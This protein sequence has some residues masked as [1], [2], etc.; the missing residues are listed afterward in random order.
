MPAVDFTAA[1]AA[2]LEIGRESRYGPAR[3]Q[4]MPAP[5]MAEE[6]DYG[7][8]LG[9]RFIIKRPRL[10]RLLDATRSRIVMLI[11]PAGYGKT[12]LA[13]EWLADRRHGW[14]RGTTAS[15]DVAALAVGLA[16]V[17]AGVVA[18][19][20]RRM[21]E[22]LVATGTPEQDVDTLAD[23]LAEDLAEWPEDAWIAFDDYHFAADSQFSERFVELLVSRCPVRLLLASR[24]RPSWA[25]AR[26]LLYGE[27]YEMGRSLLAMSQDEASEVLSH[28]NEAEASGLLAL[29]DGWPAVIGLAAH[30]ETL[31]LPDETL[32]GALHDY[33]AEELFQAADP[34]V[35]WGL[36]RLALIPSVRSDLARAVLE[37]STERVF[38]EGLRLGFLTTPAKG[39]IDLHPLLRAFLE[40]KLRD[41]PRDE[42]ERAASALFD[43]LVGRELWD[44]AFSVVEEYYRGESFLRLL[45][46]AMPDLLREARLPTLSRWLECA[47]AHRTESPLI[48]LADAELAFRQGDKAQ[49]ETLALQ[50]AQGLGDGHRLTSAAY[51]LAGSSAHLRYRDALA[52]EHFDRAQATATSERD[53][54][55]ALWGRFL[56]TVGLEQAEEASAIFVR[57]EERTPRGPEGLA[58]LANGLI[59]LSQLQGDIREA[60]EWATSL[61]PSPEMVDPLVYSSFLNSC[62]SALVLSARYEEAR[63]AAEQELLDAERFRLNFVVPHACIYSAAAHWGLRTFGQC[64]ALLDRVHR[65][66]SPDDGFLIMSVGT[67]RARLHLTS[68]AVSL[69]L[70]AMEAHHHPLA[71]VGMQA[72]YLAWWSLVLACANRSKE[73]LRLAREAEGETDRVEVKALIPWTHAI[74]ST[75]RSDREAARL[76]QHAFD[77]ARDT[78]NLDSFVVAYRSCPDILA[79]L[80][81]QRSNRWLMKEVLRRACDESL[82]RTVGLIFS[83]PTRRST[84][85]LSKREQEVFDL[86]GQGLS[87]REIARTLYISEA[88]VKVHVRHIFEKLGV[89]S[90]TEAALRAAAERGDQATA[91]A[92]SE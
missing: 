5:D 7:E 42:T 16:K 86:L 4:D 18:D 50:A 20:G 48:Y 77:T 79:P 3:G 51:Y 74:L 76:V 34:E 30:A 49:A 29:A 57:Y 70:E 39:V 80:A 24:S 15:S 82:G 1:G 92:G 60:V 47:A 38:T 83:G 63:R 14:Y 72:E 45:E 25:T 32:P 21:R 12:T 59:V 64:A 90:R 58:R 22:R 84:E 55:Q 40:T 67:L 2:L 89:R 65:L 37:E 19:A 8:G 9:S 17:A 41:H 33:F 91:T 28:R 27:C 44:D 68:G 73:A 10:T 13:R 11:A 31:E 6:S 36:A 43:T 46:A 23:M 53:E 75:Q 35:Q 85:L 71:T 81:K 26:R 62:A 78:G 87:N 52:L 56:A 54:L 69:A 66:S 61:S 88:T